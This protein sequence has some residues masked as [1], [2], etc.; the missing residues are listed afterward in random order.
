L[1]DDNTDEINDQSWEIIA[2][3]CITEPK[4]RLKLADIPHQLKKMDLEDNRPA[5]QPLPGA[6]ILQDRRPYGAVDIY[7]T[8]A[9]LGELKVSWCLMNCNNS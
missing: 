7:G 9:I 1:A 6:E 8:E 2:G 5:A 4:G 3:C